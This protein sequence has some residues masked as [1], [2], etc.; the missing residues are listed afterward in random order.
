LS[1]GNPK[2]LLRQSLLAIASCQ[3]SYFR[4][5]LLLFALPAHLAVRQRKARGRVDRYS[6]PSSAVYA[7]VHALKVTILSTMLADQSIGEWGFSAL[8]EA[9][10]RRVLVDT[11]NRPATVLQNAKELGLNLS[12]VSEVVL[13]HNHDEHVGGLLTLCRELM[14]KNRS[15]LS[16]VHVAKG[17]F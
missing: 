16:R 3:W 2:G 10:G 14:K 13:T 12:T 15:A 11:G 8:V 9:D 1:D 5:P 17:I 4:A 7:Q 6:S